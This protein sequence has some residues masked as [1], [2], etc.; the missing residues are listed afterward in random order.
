MNLEKLCRFELFE[1]QQLSKTLTG[2]KRYDESRLE[3]SIKGAHLDS[4]FIEVLAEKHAQYSCL[5]F[6]IVEGVCCQIINREQLLFADHD[7]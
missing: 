3:M 5:R 4:I 6:C 2:D 1:K 7:S